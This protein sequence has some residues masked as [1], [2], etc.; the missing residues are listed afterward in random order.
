MLDIRLIRHD[1]E[2]VRSALA[3]RG[4]EAAASVNSVL[5]LDERWRARTTEAEDL[6]AELNRRS[7][8]LKGAPTSER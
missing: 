4:P 7:R 3:R 1:P 8:A 5:E 6:R 2:G